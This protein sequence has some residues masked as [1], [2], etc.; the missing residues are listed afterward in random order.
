MAIACSIAS[1]GQVV[2]NDAN[3]RVWNGS[4][5]LVLRGGAQ[6]QSVVA[7]PGRV[8]WQVRP[9]GLGLNLQLTAAC[10][11]A[12]PLVSRLSLGWNRLGWQINDH[13]SEWPAGLLAGLGTPW[14][15]VLA[16]GNLALNVTGLSVEW[17]QG[18]S[19]M[20]GRLQ[21]DAL[22]MTSSLSTL[23]PMG[24]YRLT[25]YGGSVNTLKLETLQGSLQLAGAGQWVG[26]RLRFEGEASAAPERQE[27]LANL[28]NIIGRRDGARS[29][30]KL[31]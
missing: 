24:S 7:L 30:I 11:M 13:Q 4:A 15:T 26:G 17:S 25:L 3:G 16:Q 5:Q 14:N 18:R 21:M 1:N 6:S 27:A 23:K 28:L 9:V 22:E 29:V 20:E 2:L 10:C 8:S 12:Q 19:A 31:G